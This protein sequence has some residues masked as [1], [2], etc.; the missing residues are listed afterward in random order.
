VACGGGGGRSST[1]T[2]ADLDGTWNVTTRVTAIE[3]TAEGVT[4]D[5]TSSFA[6]TITLQGTTVLL[7]DAGGGVTTARLEGSRVRAAVEVPAAPRLRTITTDFGVRGGQLDGSITTRTTDAGRLVGTVVEALVG[8]RAAA[9]AVDAFIAGVQ[10][11]NGTAAA[12]VA[13]PVPGGGGGPAISTGGARTVIDG[14][15]N[16]VVVDCPSGLD[17]VLV[18]VR[19]AEGYW[20]IPLQGPQTVVELVLALAAAIPSGSFDCVFAGERNGAVG[21]PVPATMTRRAVGTGRLQVNLSWDSPADLDLHV[22]EPD[23]T[24]VWYGAQTSRNGGELDLDSNAGCTAGISN[25]NVTYAGAP[26]AGEYIVRVDNYDACT[27]PSS[28]FVVRI[29]I[30][31]RPPMVYRGT[32]TGPG[33]GAGAGGGQEIARFTF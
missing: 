26:P 7:R 14:G 8:R 33:T 10:L 4:L 6:V 20:R 22:V 24:E 9:G 21:P 17:A 31:G 13:G 5:Q 27:A 11:P 29:N 3:G 28:G 16:Q 15:T 19:D 32:M 18:S 2:A 25:E 1:L 23:G 30:E 12:R